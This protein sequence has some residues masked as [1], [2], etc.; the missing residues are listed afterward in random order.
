MKKPQIRRFFL[1]IGMACGIM[2]YMFIFIYG[3]QIMQ[4]VIEEKTS[5]VVEVIVSSVKPF[6]L[7][8]GKIMG[9]ASVG[10]LQFLIWIILITTLSSVVL[11]FFGLEMPQQQMM[12]EMNQQYPDAQVQNQGMMEVM[13]LISEIPFGYLIFNF[14]FYFLGG[15]L[16]Y[17]ALVRSSRICRR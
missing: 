13:K 4:G 6:Q 11:G 5:K 15:Y 9:L 8:M 1:A 16:L 14:L 12:N 17:G 7:M 3:A 10:L 2:M